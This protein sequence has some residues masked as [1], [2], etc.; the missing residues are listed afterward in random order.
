MGMLRVG[1]QHQ[2]EVT[3]TGTTIDP[4]SILILPK[5]KR[6]VVSQVFV[7]AVHLN[8]DRRFLQPKPGIGVDPLAKLVLDAAYEATLYAALA[9]K[10]KNVLLTAV[11]MYHGNKPS[12]IA[13]AVVRAHEKFCCSGLDVTFVC[14]HSGGMNPC[15]ACDEVF[16]RLS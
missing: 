15:D 1:V 16:V 8:T 3:C 11:G 9:C 4:V 7:S 13:D 2:V 5:E 14:C 12:W 6:H 10:V